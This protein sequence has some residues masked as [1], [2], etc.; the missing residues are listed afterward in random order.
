MIIKYFNYICNKAIEYL[1]A[2]GEID[3]SVSLKNDGFLLTIKDTM[4]DR[5]ESDIIDFVRICYDIRKD[6]IQNNKIKDI[7]YYYKNDKRI[8]ELYIRCNYDF[9]N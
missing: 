9:R 4:E 7:K 2:Y 8:N 6:L 1:N 5:D 3:T